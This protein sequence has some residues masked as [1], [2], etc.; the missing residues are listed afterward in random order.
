VHGYKNIIHAIN[1]CIKN[2]ENLYIKDNKLFKPIIP[3]C[4]NMQFIAT[5]GAFWCSGNP[6]LHALFVSI[7]GAFAIK[8]VFIFFYIIG[9]FSAVYDFIGFQTDET[10]MIHLLLG[11]ILFIDKCKKENFISLL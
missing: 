5:D 11:H 7:C 9:V 8:C 4:A 1:N 2:N 6:F 10:F 3:I